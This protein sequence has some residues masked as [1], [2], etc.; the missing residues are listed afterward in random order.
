MTMEQLESAFAGALPDS[1]QLDPATNILNLR[2]CIDTHM[3]LLKANSGNAKY[4]PFY[5]RLVA[6]AG[7]LQNT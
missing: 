4:L 2:K 1:M 5:R 6:I 3:A 7:K